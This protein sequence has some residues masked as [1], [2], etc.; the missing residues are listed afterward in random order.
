MATR[1]ALSCVRLEKIEGLPL[2]S[3]FSA[4]SRCWRV[5][6]DPVLRFT[7]YLGENTNAGDFIDGYDVEAKQREM[8]RIGHCPSASAA[9]RSARDSLR[10]DRGRRRERPLPSVPFLVERGRFLPC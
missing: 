1:G 5:D 4:L 6:D 3:A 8:D 9:A 10:A 7:P 2:S